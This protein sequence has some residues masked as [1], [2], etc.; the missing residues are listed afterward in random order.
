MSRFESDHR[1]YPLPCQGLTR[2]GHARLAGDDEEIAK[3]IGGVLGI[4]SAADP[5]RPIQVPTKEVLP[6]IE[7]RDRD[8]TEP[9]TSEV[10]PFDLN[11]LISQQRPD[12]FAM[13]MP[14]ASQPPRHIGQI[15]EPVLARRGE[16]QRPAGFEHSVQLRQDLPFPSGRQVFENRE[17]RHRVKSPVSE[18]EALRL[19]THDGDRRGHTPA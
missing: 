4:E 7:H 19:G 13:V 11:P 17:K 3:T 5:W 2:L 15:A 14:V 12:L 6:E 10:E 18:W 1:W 16:D 8:G 9:P